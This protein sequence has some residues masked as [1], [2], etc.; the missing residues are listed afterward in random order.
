MRLG[1][2]CFFLIAW[3]STGIWAQ[4]PHPFN[5]GTLDGTNGVRLDGYEESSWSGSAASGAGDVDGDGYPDL[6]TGAFNA[7][8]TGS[9][10]P[11][12][13]GE[14][15]LVFGASSLAHPIDLGALSGTDGVRLVGAGQGDFSGQ[16]VS[17]AGD[18]D[19]DGH[20]DFLIGAAGA[21]AGGAESGETYLIFGSTA[22]S[23]PIDL[24]TVSGTVGLRINGIDAG[25][26]S[27]RVAGA[28]DVNS[29]GFD[30]FL[31]GAPDADG[32]EAYLIF[33]GPSIPHPLD[34]GALNGTNGVRFDSAGTYDNSGWAVSGAGDVNG[35]GLPD[36][37]I[38][39]YG[40][41][42][43]M[44]TA[45]GNTHLIYG[46]PSLTHPFDLGSLDGTDG[47]TFVGI[48]QG[49]MSG[50]SVS[51][52][53]DVNG[54]GFGDL[55]IGAPLADWGSDDAAGE[56]YLI[57]GAPSLAHPFDLSTLDGAT[58]V[59]FDGVIDFGECGH[60]VS[61]AGD[62]NGDGLADMLFGAPQADMGSGD[63][64]GH[65]YLVYGST[66]ISHPLALPALDGSN[67]VRFEGPDPN[68]SAGESVAC[69]GDVNLDGL[70]DILIGASGGDPGGAAAAGETHL[71]YGSGTSLSGT[72]QA[73]C[74][75]DDAPPL[76]IGLPG[77]GSVDVPATRC[78][79][80]HSSGSG[81]GNGSS[82]LE[83][84]TL[85]RS[86]SEIGN[87]DPI[88]DVADVVWEITTNRTGWSIAT[89]TLCY[90]D[91]EIDHIV[92]GSE[93]D[94]VICQAPALSGP[95]TRLPTTVDTARNT[96]SATVTGFSHFAILDTRGATTSVE[97]WRPYR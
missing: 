12:G 6:L 56:S 52:A 14:T 92:G 16:S 21:D 30:D 40:A 25:D 91:S 67:G 8:F 76:G 11:D 51:G 48:D 47:V 9:G 85:T 95:W 74:R 60:S 33:G 36:F 50:H 35:D 54:D 3:I 93:G 15:F 42:V 46:S 73:F 26:E 44:Q 45:F 7:G 57:Y 66:S 23:H 2:L 4:L 80:D 18:V 75:A 34:L 22:L 77:G 88:A 55:L 53:G 84:V 97:T 32:G 89:L 68:D 24:G 65:A 83:T 64:V 1:G 49:D 90:L 5:L 62:V 13:W 31:I 70:A 96:A 61:A 81:P 63:E 79:I 27:G 38:G 39:A 19:G 78:W 87:L 59:Q 69:A 29:D 10:Y 82:S 94:L 28:G 17:G 71:V 41:W 58:G 43:G 37:L 86:N 72:C 20:A